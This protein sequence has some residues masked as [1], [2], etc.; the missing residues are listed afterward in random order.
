MFDRELLGLVAA[1]PTGVAAAMAVLGS[2]ALLAMRSLSTGTTIVAVTGA[3]PVLASVTVAGHGAAA[4]RVLGRALVGIHLLAAAFWIGSLWPL[5]DVARRASP[6]EATEVLHRF[7]SVAQ[8]VVAV[9]VAAGLGLALLLL[10]SVQALWSTPYGRLLSIKLL[11]VA[12]LL[13]LAALNR[14]RLV[15]HFAAGSPTAPAALARSIHVECVVAALIVVAA[16]LL[17]TYSTPFT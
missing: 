16:A 4:A 12:G 9:L 1:S 17:T 2:V 3:L 5:L 14:L 15:P 10:D 13:A 8:G 7:G 11:L 6:R